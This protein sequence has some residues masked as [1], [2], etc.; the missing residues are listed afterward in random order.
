M[1]LAALALLLAQATPAISLGEQGRLTLCLEEARR[2]PA[3]A[4][5]TASEWLGEASGAGSALAQHCLGQ[6]YVSLLRW[7]AAEEAFLAGRDA[8][9]DVV[10]RARLGAMAGNAALAAERWD[11]AL[12]A[13]AVA[14]VDAAAANDAVLAGL[15]AAD[16]ARALVALGEIDA[17][18]EALERARSDD[19]QNAEAWLLSA[20][21]ARR[22]GD[23]ATA[24]GLIERAAA[25]A[26]GDPQIALEAGVIALLAGDADA[27]QGAW[28]MVQELAPGTPEAAIAEDYL[29]QLEGPGE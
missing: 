12:A 19:P 2:D 18:G 24:A 26:S 7:Q 27:A 21:L 14:Q 6:A 16:R 9:A 5:S 4:I 15:I 17:A 29:T 23:I 11:A 28:E 25:L 8:T 3:T 1:I 22:Q 10:M 13:L 20:T